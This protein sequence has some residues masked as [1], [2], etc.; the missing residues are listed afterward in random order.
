[1]THRFH[2]LHG[3]GFVLLA[4]RHNRAE[5]RVVFVDG[6]CQF[7]SLPAP[8][9]SLAPPDPLLTPAAGRSAFRVADRLVLAHLP[10]QLL[11][12]DGPTRWIPL[13]PRRPEASAAPV[14]E[15]CCGVLRAS[16]RR[17]PTRARRPFDASVDATDARRRVRNLDM[18]S[19]ASGGLMKPPPPP[20]LCFDREGHLAKPTGQ[21]LSEDNIVADRCNRAMI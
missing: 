3:R 11:Q 20:E 6:P 16:V 12:A 15:I 9:T 5:D 18:S 2:P 8:W 13:R 7:V 17:H 14:R 4:H 1:V 19:R 21:V 10:E